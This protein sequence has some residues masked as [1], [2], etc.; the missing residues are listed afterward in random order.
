MSVGRARPAKAVAQD[1]AGKVA[2]W[3]GVCNYWHD[4]TASRRSSVWT[5]AGR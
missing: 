1:L 4:P 3:R 5:G 2:V